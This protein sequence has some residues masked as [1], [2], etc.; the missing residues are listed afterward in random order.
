MT[1]KLTIQDVKQI[2]SLLKQKALELY[3]LGQYVSTWD[4]IDKAVFIIQEFN[5]EYT[6]DDLESLLQ[7]LACQWIPDIPQKN[8][9]NDNRVVVI[10]DWCTSYVLVLQY[11]EALV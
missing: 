2:Y 6:D 3:S 11:I 9:P 8:N 10:D 1:Y 4:V 5:W 7:Q